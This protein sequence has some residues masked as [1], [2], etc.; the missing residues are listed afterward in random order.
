MHVADQPA[1]LHIAHDVLHG[2]EGLGGGGLVVHG[3]PD[4]GDDLQ[5][6]HEQGQRAEKIPEVEVLGRV[7]ASQVFVPQPRQ[8]KPLIH[9]VSQPRQGPSQLAHAET[10]PE[11]SPINTRASLKY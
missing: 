9:P 1:P 5:D 4:A 8:R 6:Q 10:P 2:G 7:V 11:S 3:Q